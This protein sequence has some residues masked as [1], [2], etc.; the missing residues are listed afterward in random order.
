MDD[1]EI[2][3]GCGQ[4]FHPTAASVTPSRRKNDSIGFRHLFEAAAEHFK[5]RFVVIDEERV[6]HKDVVCVQCGRRLGDKTLA[7][8]DFPCMG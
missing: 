5:R 6:Q 1:F 3:L 8:I 2:I 7:F 4:V